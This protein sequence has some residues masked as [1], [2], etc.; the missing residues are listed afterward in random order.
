[1]KNSLVF[2]AAAAAVAASPG[3]KIKF[4]LTLSL[5][6]LL[7]LFHFIFLVVIM[8][9]GSFFSYVNVRSFNP[10]FF[11]LALHLQTDKKSCVCSFPFIVIAH[12]KSF[13]A[14]FPTWAWQHGNMNENCVY[15]FF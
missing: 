8:R 12:V 7:N 11:I 1:V 14:L 9:R 2:A 15:S 6:C 3:G 4:F 10:F 13:F 5:V